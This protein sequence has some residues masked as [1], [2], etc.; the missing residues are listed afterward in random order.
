MVTLLAPQPIAKQ[1]LP[2]KNGCF[3][4]NINKDYFS[5]GYFIPFT[6]NKW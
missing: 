3:V 2:P 6:G 5:F 4:K 1:G